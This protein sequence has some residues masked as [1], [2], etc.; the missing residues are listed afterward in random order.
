MCWFNYNKIS[1]SLRRFAKLVTFVAFILNLGAR[2]L[3]T[4]RLTMCTIGIKGG[5]FSLCLGL[6]YK[7]R[8]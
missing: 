4:L 7:Y 8:S 2:S 6:K 3:S 5:N 1:H